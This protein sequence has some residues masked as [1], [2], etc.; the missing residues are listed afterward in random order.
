MMRIHLQSTSHL[1][2]A[3]HVADSPRFLQYLPIEQDLPPPLIYTETAIATEYKTVTKTQHHTHTQPTI[4]TMPA[5][6]NT[7]LAAFPTPQPVT[8]SYSTGIPKTTAVQYITEDI[9]EEQ[10]PIV[11]EIIEE[12][13]EVVMSPVTKVRARGPQARPPKRWLGGW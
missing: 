8:V 13:E 10:A 11:E 3:D 4:V 7:R 2:V 12:E 6:A 9:I 1:A 5:P